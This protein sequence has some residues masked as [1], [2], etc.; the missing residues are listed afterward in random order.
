MQSRP[1][2]VSLGL[3]LLVVVGFV[4]P[5]S[6]DQIVIGNA[7]PCGGAVTCASGNTAFDLTSVLSGSTPLSFGGTPFDSGIVGLT[8]PID[9]TFSWSGGTGLAAGASF[10][11]QYQSPE[12]GNS[13][14]VTPVPEPASLALLG[15]GMLVLVGLCR[16]RRRTRVAHK[17]ALHPTA[18]PTGFASH[19]SHVSAP[20]LRSA[21]T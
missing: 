10:T 7:Q 5:A 14:T 4:T 19:T 3:L 11:L 6:A 1:V 2:A 12:V 8:N 18:E 13:F 16:R 17:A 9:L 20:A 15:S 21:S